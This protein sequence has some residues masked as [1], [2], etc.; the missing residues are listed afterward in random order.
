MASVKPQLDYYHGR[1]V[2]KVT[3]DGDGEWSIV[4]EGNVI[5]RNH[6]ARRTSVPENIEGLQYLFTSYTEKETV[7][8][9]GQ[10]P[11]GGREWVAKFT[12]AKYSISGEGIDGEHYPQRLDEEEQITVPG[13]YQ[14]EYLAE[15]EQEGPDEIVIDKDTIARGLGTDPRSDVSPSEAPEEPGEGKATSEDS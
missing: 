5:V 15:R 10:S 11:E 1:K 6:D 2:E 4:L 13:I 7:M 9:F 3:H 12:P 14:E 8:Q